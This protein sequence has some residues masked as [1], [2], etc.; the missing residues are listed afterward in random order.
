LIVHYKADVLF[1]TF[2][3]RFLF[4]LQICGLIF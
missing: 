3:F 2:P 1:I 4:Y